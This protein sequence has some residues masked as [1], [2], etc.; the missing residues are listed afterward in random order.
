M[1]LQELLMNLQELLIKQTVFE[2]FMLIAFYHLYL[3]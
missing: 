1:N 3:T 2:I